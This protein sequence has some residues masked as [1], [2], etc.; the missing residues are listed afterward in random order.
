MLQRARAL[1]IDGDPSFRATLRAA[2]GVH[3]HVV[4]EAR[5]GGS[6]RV[7]LGRAGRP[8]RDVGA[9]AGRLRG[10]TRAARAWP[11]ARPRPAEFPRW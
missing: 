6:V 9:A 4:G 7:H 11:V 2:L 1:I 10:R 8:D 5:R 3:V